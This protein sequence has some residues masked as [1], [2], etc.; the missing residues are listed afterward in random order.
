MIDGQ[1]NSINNNNNLQ[2]ANHSLI[3]Q[4]ILSSSQAYPPGSTMLQRSGSGPLLT[5]TY[6]QAPHYANG[7]HLQRLAPAGGMMNSNNNSTAPSLSQ[8]QL[9]H[10]TMGAG[11]G[12][13]GMPLSVSSQQELVRQQAAAVR[14]CLLCV[15]ECVCECV[16]VCVY[17]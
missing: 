14:V 12:G 1:S 16:C 2:F 11:G 8:Q 7:E 15:R 10:Y 6:P 17:V 13:M 4:T 3:N 5:S 9:Q